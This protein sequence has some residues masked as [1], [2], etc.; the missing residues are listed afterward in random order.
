[1][2]AA[3]VR[4][5]YDYN[6]WANQRILAQAVKLTPAQLRAENALGWGSFL[7][8]LAH[9][10]A[11]E[12]RWTSRLFDQPQTAGLDANDFKD[13]AALQVRWAQE[14][15]R[16]NSCLDA[17]TDADL[18][19]SYTRQRKGR[20]LTIRLWQALLHVV[21]HGTQHRA[22]CAA[23][24]TGWGHSPGDLDMTVYLS[25]HQPLPQGGAMTSQAMQLLYAYN[26][27]AN[28]RIF[29]QASLLTDERLRQPNDF[30]WGSLFGAL[31]HIL[32]AEYGWRHFLERDEDVKWLEAGDFADFGALRGRWAVEN[33]EMRRFVNG[34]TD[35]DLLRKVYYDVDGEQRSH[36]LWHCLAHVV[37]H[38]TQHRAECAALLTDMGHSPGDMDFTVF[39]SRQES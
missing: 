27:W 39:L 11:A 28:T 26:E 18:A 32:D 9:A 24:L 30:G 4:L 17:L 19:H 6:H 10:M 38:G 8:G 31:T 13:V 3:A 25:Q 21:N 7:G 1:M 15:A 2:N 33:A 23:L 12:S 37:N 5:L 29:A 14:T 35:A 16:L 36:I 34:L 20:S 22:E